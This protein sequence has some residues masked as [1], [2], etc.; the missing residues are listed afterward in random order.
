[1]RLILFAAPASYRIANADLRCF[2]FYRGA[3]GYQQKTS[4]LWRALNLMEKV[5][6]CRAGRVSIN[7]GSEYFLL[8][9]HSLSA[10][11]YV[12]LPE[13]KYATYIREREGLDWAM[14][15]R[16]SQWSLSM[17]GRHIFTLHP[18]TPSS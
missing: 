6:L 7:F 18:L 2:I 10:F 13:Y 4:C 8:C 5:A 15:G 12:L 9:T 14:G 17:M 16:N 11:M 1:M 3:G